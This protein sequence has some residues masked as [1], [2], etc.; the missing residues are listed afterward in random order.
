VRI[1]FKTFGC[2]LN[3][4]ETDRF[5]AD[6]SAAGWQVVPFAAPAEV[7]VVHGCA[8]THTAGLKCLQLARGIKRAAQAAEASEPFVV[9]VGCVVEADAARQDVAGVDLLV[10]RGDKERLVEILCARLGRGSADPA[11]LPDP[12]NPPRALRRKRAF[13][14]VQDGCDF[15]CTYCIVPHT[16][17]APVS[18]P[19][20][21]VL[22]EARALA[23]DGFAE[24]VITGCNVACY[25]DG[26]RGLADLLAAIAAI[27]AVQRIRLSS[28][29]PGTS[30]R[31]IID[32]MSACRKLCRYLHLPLQ[33]GDADTL[34]RMGRKYTPESFAA[35]VQHAAQRMPDLGLGTDIIA[36][37]PGE[38]DAAFE[39][40]RQLVAALPF[41]NLHVFPYSERPGTPAVSFADRVPVSVRKSRARELIRLGAEKRQAF[42]LR[43][44]GRPVEVLIER[45]GKDGRGGGW[46]SEY[47][48]C[49]V[50]GVSRAQIGR[51]VPFTPTGVEPG[52]VLA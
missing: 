50:A 3:Q 9:L 36:G 28:V 38:T 48:D 40:T 7:V 21:Q 1:A 19:W 29:E 46:S 52:G 35:M 22:D 11:D 43:F 4:A 18:R 16:R 27:G 33:S 32:L 24:L 25:R 44:V 8:V 41:S 17:G 23:Q 34:R 26:A 14:K 39:R 6:F 47:L 42:A 12:P 20:P 2:R 51:I 10:A 30:E 49:R 45:V 13:L 5:A 31:E 15:F 37:F